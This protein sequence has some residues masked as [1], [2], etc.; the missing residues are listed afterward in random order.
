VNQIRR[1]KFLLSA[2][3]LLAAPHAAWAQQSLPVIGYLGVE[4]PERFASRLH[5]FREG[6]AESGFIE[7]RNVAIEYRWAE[8]Q[9]AR[10][11]ELAADLARRQVAVIAAPGSIASALAAKAATGTIPIVFEVGADPVA[12]GLVANLNRPGG[13]VTGVT[14]LNTAIGAKRVQLLHEMVQGAKRF[15]LLVNPTNPRN[16]EPTTRES[17]EAAR[18]LG[19]QLHVLHA[20]TDEELAAVFT[21]LARLRAGGLVIANDPFFVARARELAAAALNHRM[22]AIQ[23]SPDFALAGGL[24]SYGGSFAESHRLAGAY[25]GRILRGQN[26]AE[27]PVQQITKAEMYI[28]LKTARAMG[29]AIPQSVLIRADRVIE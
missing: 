29:L 25:V 6:L 20:S 12:S 15:G 24:V 11:P 17:R 4:S 1:R 2:G 27:L 26:P 23:L 21:S 7:G 19:L 10:L 22:P 18:A 5:A 16:A 9:N 14:S 13:N 28:N 3:A 8:G